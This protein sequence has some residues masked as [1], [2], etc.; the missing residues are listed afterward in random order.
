M[1]GTAI[2]GFSFLSGG[3]HLAKHSNIGGAAPIEDRPHLS[4]S[5][6]PFELRQSRIRNLGFPVMDQV[7]IKS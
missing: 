7:A 3:E 4:V 2:S 5:K 1:E 6:E